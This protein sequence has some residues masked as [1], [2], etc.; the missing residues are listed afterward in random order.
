MQTPKILPLIMI[1]ITFTFLFLSCKNKNNVFEWTLRAWTKYHYL[2]EHN[3][4]LELNVIRFKQNE[5]KIQK[6]LK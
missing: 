6:N 1:I 4:I 5:K 2:F 3:F